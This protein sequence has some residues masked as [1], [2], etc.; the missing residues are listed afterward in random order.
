MKYIKASLIWFVCF[1]AVTLN[2][3]AQTSDTFDIATFQPPAGWTK[4]SNEKGLIFTTADNQKNTFAMVVLYQSD[5]SSGDPRRDFDSDWQQFIVGTFPVK[6]DPQMEPQKQAE[7]WTM[8]TGGA[9]FDGELGTSAVILSTYSG[10]GRKF[11]A[12]A[13][14]NSQ[15]YLKA[16]DAFASSIVLNRS[17][18][19]PPGQVAAVQTENSILGTWGKNQGAHMTYGDPVAA[20][21]AGYSKDQYTFNSNG[22][23]AFVSKTFRMSYDKIILVI[24]NGS[25]QIN[26]NTIS[27][28]PQKSVIQAWSKLNGGDKFGRL[29][30]SQ[31]RK[32]EPVD[33]RFT[34][35]YFSGIDQWQLVLQAGSPTER[36]GPYS[37][38]TLFNNAWYYSPISANNPVVELPN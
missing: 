38:L 6:G 33:Y 23:Y 29:V 20:G 9:A 25:Y 12:A 15:E 7:G 34:R 36:D 4:K 2:V 26:G 22:T 8:T 31:N 27:I 24:E 11:S 3:R 13:I 16:I 5:K 37:T 17:V 14:F 28:K 32:L 21:M 18:A 19:K 1:L 35:H 30:T 10:F